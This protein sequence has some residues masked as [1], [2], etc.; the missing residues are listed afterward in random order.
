MSI[1][2]K[3]QTYNYEIYFL[4]ALEIYLKIMYNKL[5][6]FVKFNKMFQ[7]FGD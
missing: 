2:P 3:K 7:G 5:K 1:F 6:R 4:R